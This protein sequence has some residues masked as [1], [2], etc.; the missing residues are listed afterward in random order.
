MCHCIYIRYT[1]SERSKEK[2][3]VTIF[4]RLVTLE[5]IFG[6]MEGNQSFIV[7]CLLIEEGLSI[8]HFKYAYNKI[9]EISI[10]KSKLENIIIKKG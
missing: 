8:Y 6:F 7:K 10:L 3:P 9:L 4:F 5:M 2:I 1:L